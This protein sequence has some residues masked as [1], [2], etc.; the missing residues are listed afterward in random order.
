MH[1]GAV[2]GLKMVS[3]VRSTFWSG[4]SRQ[5]PAQ[6][7]T[8][9]WLARAESQR[10]GEYATNAQLLAIACACRYQA[11]GARQERTKTYHP[12]GPDILVRPEETRT[13]MSVPRIILIAFPL[14]PQD[15]IGVKARSSLIEA[16]GQHP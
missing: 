15:R 13:G 10:T 11:L 12:S 9:A 3:V 5:S 6:S 16:V 1:W 8:R 4:A 14:R 2:S 7:S